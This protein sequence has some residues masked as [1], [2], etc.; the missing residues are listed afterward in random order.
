MAKTKV[1]FYARNKKGKK[2]KV[3]FY[4]RKPKRRKATSKTSKKGR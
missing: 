4:A 1:S 3:T 2:V